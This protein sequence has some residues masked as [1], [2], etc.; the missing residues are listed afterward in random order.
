MGVNVAVPPCGS[1]VCRGRPSC[2]HP[3][4]SGCASQVILTHHNACTAN[5]KLQNQKSRISDETLENKFKDELCEW[6][7]RS[8]R[9]T[10]VY[11]LIEGRCAPDKLR[12]DG[13]RKVS[14]VSHHRSGFHEY[15]AIAYRL[16]Q[17]RLFERNLNSLYCSYHLLSAYSM[18]CREYPC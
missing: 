9:K 13:R 4:P 8:T 5:Q 14:C 16:G 6:A 12:A 10:D 3:L 1:V 18:S 15:P 17:R 11:R 7:K 2:L